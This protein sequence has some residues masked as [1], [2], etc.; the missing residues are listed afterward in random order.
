[1]KKYLVLAAMLAALPGVAYAQ[2]SDS[3]TAAQSFDGVRAEARLGYETPTVSGNGEVYKIGSAVSYGGELGFDIAAGKSVVVGPY[4]VYEFSSV[5]LCDGPACLSEK[6]NLGVGGRVG[7]VVS[8]NVL[9]YGK[10]GYARISFKASSGS[11]VDSD[12]KGGVQG[13]LG[14][15]VNFGKHAYGA[16]EFNYGD[17]GKYGAVNLQRRHVAVGVGFRF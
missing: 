15:N 17:Y 3:T 7:V 11:F 10:A 2:D 5:K 16:L 14:V 12:S 6:G 13:A 4:A 9:I 1:M 8:P